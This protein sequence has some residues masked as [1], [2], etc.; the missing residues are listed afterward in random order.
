MAFKLPKSVVIEGESVDTALVIVAESAELNADDEVA[1]VVVEAR[2]VFRSLTWMARVMDWKRSPV[3]D[4][5]SEFRVAT[6]ELRVLRPEMTP[7]ASRFLWTGDATVKVE[8]RRK[9]MTVLMSCILSV[10]LSEYF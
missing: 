9:V 3:Y 1:A 4:K 8:A 6:L 7:A 5:A 2:V 10:V